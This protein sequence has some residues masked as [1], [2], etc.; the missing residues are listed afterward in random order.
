MQKSNATYTLELTPKEIQ[1]IKRWV[2]DGAGYTSIKQKF[3]WLTDTE[4][5]NLIQLQ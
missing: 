5:H 2:L 1:M 4:V 3:Q